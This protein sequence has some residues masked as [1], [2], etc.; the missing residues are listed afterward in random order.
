[1][2]FALFP[3]ET[4]NIFPIANSVNGGQLVTEFN[5][6]SRESVSTDPSVEYIIGP[7]Y[8]HSMNDYYVTLG[9]STSYFDTTT[10]ISSTKLQIAPGRAV[11]NGHY[12]ENLTPMEIDIAE[13]NASLPESERLSGNL[14][15][16]LRVFYSTEA[17]MSG[18]I[19]AEGTVDGMDVYTGIQVVILPTEEFL[20]P[21]STDSEGNY[22]GKEENQNLVTAHLLLATF[23]FINGAVIDLV[24]NPGKM[25][26]VPA[27]RIQNINNM[28]SDEYV[29][30]TGMNPD[31]L[32]VF[33]G[34]GT[35]PDTGYDTWCAAEDSLIVWDAIPQM[36]T[37]IP[38]VTE[39][40]FT[41]T[42]GGRTVLVL[43]HKQIDKADA[44]YSP[45]DANGDQKYYIPKTLALPLADFNAETP[46]TVNSAYTANVKKITAQIAN[47]YSLT[48]G[49]QRAYIEVLSDI[50]DLPPVN[51]RW[52]VGDYI[53][54]GQDL[55]DEYEGLNS[56]SR[57]PS[58]IYVVMPP[59]VKMMEFFSISSAGLTGIQLASTSGSAEAGDPA[60]NTVDP[61]VYCT[62]WGDLNA[63]VYRGEVGSDYFTYTYTDANG[64]VTNFYY[65]VSDV[66][67]TRSY[68]PQIYLTRP[69]PYATQGAVGGFLDIDPTLTDN[70]Y[71][72]LDSDGHLRLLDYDLLRSGTL[73]YQLGEDFKVPSGLTVDA[74]QAYLDEYVNQRVAFPNANQIQNAT[75]PNVITITID[76]PADDA[77]GTLN[78]YSID[79][80]FN[81]SVAIN[82]LG[83]A[84][85][86]VTINIS[87]CERVR[88]LKP[89]SG[90]PVIN[91]YRSGLFYDADVLN[92][93]TTI[94]DLKLWHEQ[95]TSEDARISVEGM[96]VKAAPLSNG[97]YSDLGST[98]IDFWT[99]DSPNDNHFTVGLKS[100]TF[101]SDGTICGCGV[102][103]RNESTTNVRPG[104]YISHDLNFEIPQGPDLY[105]PRARMKKA[106]SVTGTFISAY[107]STYD[108]G[109]IV[110]ESNFTLRSPVYDAAQNIQVNGEIAFIVNS[111]VVEAAMV[112]I[113]VWNTSAFHYF[114]GVSLY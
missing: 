43:P 59:R 20:T 60:P 88:I 3:V 41:S 24:Q 1:M 89:I 37:D 46:G 86:N 111:Y 61:E 26:S 65:T 71:V 38:T 97:S 58:T 92:Y 94:Q 85:S 30:K 106:V 67:T 54:V 21:T 82:I 105:Y 72:Y 31:K 75:I 100:V 18:S 7:S 80:R 17:T 63:I 68:S 19:K 76:I 104:R 29:K 81:T 35:D 36:S 14:S 108:N 84:G 2:N 11:V 22:C 25:Q 69:I 33:A 4:T 23:K 112:P 5:L 16:G 114:Y 110:M 96:T 98:P 42:S 74:I 12:I 55:T 56:D 73:A 49:K 52:N 28:I 57:P 50:A 113:D 102:M 101:D 48:N 6:K 103:V 13:V 90:S 32:Y 34:K 45:E 66:E 87:D 109:Y 95:F 10:A 27:E 15:I 47:L 39:A 40:T 77:G 53:L 91:L 9:D 64:E 62:Y 70:G 99:Q 107:T 79:S 78:I 93:L 44:R 83:N 8:A 51:P